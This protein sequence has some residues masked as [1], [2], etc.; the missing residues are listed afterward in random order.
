MPDILQTR[1]NKYWST[2]AEAY[3]SNQSARQERPG[4]LDTWARVWGAALPAA[5]ADVLDLGTGSGNVARLLAGLRYDVTGIDLAP[6]MLARARDKCRADAN[7]PRFLEADAADPPFEPGSFDALTARYLLWT[8][9]DPDRALPA[10]RKVLRPGGVLVAVD[11][12]WYP[13]GLRAAHEGAEA[14][15]RDHHFRSA[16]DDAALERLPLAE[17]RTID[18]M[19]EL[20]EAAGFTEVAITELPEVM[21]LD[22][23]YGVAPGHRVQ[24]QYRI[25][26]RAPIPAHRPEQSRSLTP[27]V[28][29]STAFMSVD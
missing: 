1:M 17:A 13:E 5:P 22:R 12:L 7:A 11:S 19:G 4:A 9:R 3:D 14:T 18:R 6:G 15:D 26:G 29:K 10:W 21:D 27:T 24:M 28:G 2:H 23:R 25:S 8:L 16:Y 20:L